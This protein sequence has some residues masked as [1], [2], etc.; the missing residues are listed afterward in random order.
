MTTIAHQYPA[1]RQPDGRVYRR[2]ADKLGNLADGW[3]DAPAYSH[4]SYFAPDAPEPLPAGVLA[5]DPGT[6]LPMPE[7]GSE[8]PAINTTTTPKET[9][10]TDIADDGEFMPR[11]TKWM[12]FP[13]PPETPRPAS[14]FGTWG[15]YKLPDPDTGKP[16]TFPRATTI[17]ETLDDTYGLNKWKRRETAKRVFQLAT[18][19]PATVLHSSWP[20]ITAAVALE[21]IATAIAAPKVTVLDDT[22]ETIDDLMGAAE[23]R[24]LGTCV[25]AWLEALDMG[26]VLL[27][28]VPEVVRPHVVNAR[29]VIAHRGL[30]M[31]PE[32]VERTVLN[33]RVEGD[34]VAGK[35]DRIAKIVATGDLVVLDVKT[36]K[37][38]SFGYGWLTN[39]VQVGGVYSWADKIL[40]LDGRSWEP[41]PTLRDDFAILLH[42]PSDQPSK[43]A[44][45]TINMWWGGEVFAESLSARQRRK[46]AKVQVP[47]H[48]LPAPTPAA[49]RYA[50]ARLA[51]SEITTAAEGQ[52]VYE[53][54]QDVWDDDLGEFATT[55]AELV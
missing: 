55:V 51:L 32:Y 16:A 17:A 53:T 6:G 14:Q 44:A 43:A 37:V 9:P 12:R 45:I 29:R 42:V 25:H 18:M 11:E 28:D 7:G 26:I 49:I 38:D 19:D 27:K 54:Y 50:E 5:Q 40:S 36:S 39:G 8:P 22:L 52:T 24:E 20:D 30:V 47:K 21:Q 34:P 23:A 13:L 31:L 46:E 1:R 3:T 48:A 15:W 2:S 41:M 4:P 10:V 33:D 35:L